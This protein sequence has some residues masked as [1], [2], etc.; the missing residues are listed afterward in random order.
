MTD[1]HVEGFGRLSSRYEDGPVRCQPFEPK[2]IPGGRAGRE[3]VMLPEDMDPSQPITGFVQPKPNGIRALALPS[4]SMI[5]TREGGPMNC[6][7]NAHAG[8]RRL[9]RAFACPM[10][11][12]GEWVE[13]GDF[14]ATLSA[15]RRGKGRGVFWIFDAVPLHQWMI[16]KCTQPI[17]FRL[18][19]LSDALPA[20]ASP[21]VGMLSATS[22]A[23]P[24]V[25]AGIA[26]FVWRAGHEGIVVKKKGSLYQRRRSPLWMRW[27]QTLTVDCTVMDTVH[28]NGRLSAIMVRGPHGPLT[29]GGGWTEADAKRLEIDHEALIEVA[30][31]PM[32]G[33]GKPRHARFVRFRDDKRRRPS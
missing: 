17:E 21:H 11:F 33:T 24:G 20:A 7:L 26:E 15:F 5:V 30:F 19:E 31:N 25:V 9:D 6:A 32:P 27:K 16:D 23:S 12:D 10:V 29:I 22:V 28:R 18:K 2:P 14:N 1:L 4:L 13:P 8:L 3:L